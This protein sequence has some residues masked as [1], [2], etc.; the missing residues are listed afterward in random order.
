M[1]W[2]LSLSCPCN[3]N[4]LYLGIP[5]LRCFKIIFA[6]PSKLVPQE[7]SSTVFSGTYSQ[8]KWVRDCIFGFTYLEGMSLLCSLHSS[9]LVCPH[10]ASQSSFLGRLAGHE[11]G[12]D[13]SVSSVGVGL[14]CLEIEIEE[15]ICNLSKL[16]AQFSLRWNA[17]Q[18]QSHSDCYH[19]P[20]KSFKW[21]RA[22]SS[23][24]NKV[25]FI[26]TSSC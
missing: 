6:I 12:D 9:A 25:F 17:W 23:V 4:R 21:T 20:P 8:S 18:L 22:K 16:L 15:A 24:E 26:A 13:L 1:V 7:V 14:A 3:C 2:F 19:A 5:L 10:P 11:W